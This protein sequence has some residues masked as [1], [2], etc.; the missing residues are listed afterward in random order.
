MRVKKVN[1]KHVI[2][3]ELIFYNEISNEQKCTVLLY[4]K[5]GGEYRLTQFKLPVKGCCDFYNG[6]IFLV[7]EF[8]SYCKNCP[9][10]SD[11]ICPFPAVSF[12]IIFTVKLK[13][14]SFS[15]GQI[16]Y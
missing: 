7:P 8:Q 2:V 13:L 6:D 4:K 10:Q 14:I 16:Y 9:K 3:G 11:K 5:Q 15:L 12:S 1:R